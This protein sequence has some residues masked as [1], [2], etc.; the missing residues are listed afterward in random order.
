MRFD[1]IFKAT[2]NVKESQIVQSRLGEI[3]VRV[4]RR[5]GYLVSDENEIRGEIRKW[6]SPKLEVGFEYLNE[7]PRE[8]NGKFRAV[9]SLLPRA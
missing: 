6:I 9:M 3:V 8:T 2:S 5:D 4:V 7:I 1:Y